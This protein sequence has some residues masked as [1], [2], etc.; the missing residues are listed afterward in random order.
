MPRHVA[1]QK[2]LLLEKFGSVARIKAATAEEIATLPGIS[3]KS[4]AALLEFLHRD[5]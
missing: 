4:A 5:D 1:N 3:H 2:Q